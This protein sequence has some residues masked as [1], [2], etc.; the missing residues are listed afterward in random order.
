MEEFPFGSMGK[1]ATETL[2]ALMVDELFLKDAC[3][4]FE[5]FHKDKEQLSRDFVYTIGLNEIETNCNPRRQ[6]DAV[7]ASMAGG[8]WREAALKRSVGWW[9]DPHAAYQAM[10]GTL[11]HAALKVPHPW[12]REVQMP[13][14]P[15]LDGMIF[16]GA[17][18][19]L[20][21]L[22][23]VVRDIK[24]HK[25]MEWKWKYPTDA[26]KN[27]GKKPFT[28]YNPKRYEPGDGTA[29]QI[30]VLMRLVE[31]EEMIAVNGGAPMPETP[32]SGEAADVWLGCADRKLRHRIVPV[33][34]YTDEE[35]IARIRPHYDQF[36]MVMAEPDL[37]KRL[38][39]IGEMP[40]QGREMFNSRDG[41]CKCDKY[42]SLREA[43]DGLLPEGLRL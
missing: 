22:H 9:L 1:P 39:L 5:S 18:D 20:D 33:R 29:L 21:R 3:D 28:Y 16:S 31:A 15:I 34:R 24:T 4:H 30:N 25:C 2:A 26:E 7:T 11:V 38:V 12:E 41:T 32:Y 8:C 10:E 40:L 36:K 19:R 13:D 27:M 35:L 6:G 23:R 14:T 42:C 17:I 37:D 43:C